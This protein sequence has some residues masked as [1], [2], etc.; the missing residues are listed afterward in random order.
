MNYAAVD[1]DDSLRLARSADTARRLSLSASSSLPDFTTSSAPTS[2]TA[3]PEATSR[4]SSSGS[5]TWHPST[6]S[7]TGPGPPRTRRSSNTATEGPFF[8]SSPPRSLHALYLSQLSSPL[9]AEPPL[10]LSPCLSTAC[11]H[12]DTKPKVGQ[13][14]INGNGTFVGAG[15]IQAF[16]SFHALNCSEIHPCAITTSSSR[17][18]SRAGRSRDGRRASS[19][20]SA[21][22]RPARRC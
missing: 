16:L 17:Q 21:C 3:A 10:P 12:L 7:K 14:C 22:D 19:A 20:K 11:I 1:S 2:T 13:P 8:A 15:A 4:T 5:S 9:D 18:A 6:S